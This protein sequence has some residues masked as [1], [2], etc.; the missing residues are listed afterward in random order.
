MAQ[1][2]TTEKTVAESPRHKYGKNK[3]TQPSAPLF[4]KTNYILMIAGAVVLAIGYIAL[5]GGGS[6][7]PEKFSESLFDTRRMVVA[8]ILIVLGLVTEIFAIMWHPSTKRTP[9]EET[10]KE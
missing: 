4:R 6:D 2:I 5:T 1:I 9:T 3:E 7:N 8:P 10:T